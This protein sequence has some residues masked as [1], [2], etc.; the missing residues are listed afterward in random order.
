[1]LRRLSFEMR[2]ALNRAD[3]LAELA[4]SARSESDRQFYLDR[5][6]NWRLLARS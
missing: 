3:D 4:K 6:R 1:M 5:E 2:Y